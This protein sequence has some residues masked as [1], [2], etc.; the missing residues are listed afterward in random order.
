MEIYGARNKQAFKRSE[1]AYVRENIS[2]WILAEGSTVG[3]AE[4]IGKR[5]II[6]AGRHCLHR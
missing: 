1:A 4:R 3:K 5:R 2:R 6:L